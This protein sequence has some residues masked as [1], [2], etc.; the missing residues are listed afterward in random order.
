MLRTILLLLAVILLAVTSCK[1]SKQARTTSKK[2]KTV[3]KTPVKEKEQES[4]Q[5]AETTPEEEKSDT[6]P[7]FHDISID[8]ALS[9]IQNKFPDTKT[10][11][12]IFK[13]KRL[14]KKI[15]IG[16]VTAEEI[17]RIAET[18]KGTPHSFNGISKKGIDCSGLVAVSFRQSGISEFP[19]GSQEQAYYGKII[20]KI[21]QLQRG[22]LVFFTNTYQTPNLLTHVGIYLGNN[23]FIHSTTSKGVIVTDFTTSEYWRRHYAF[24]TRLF[25]PA[26]TVA[27]AG[28]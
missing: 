20:L 26:Q 25:N 5:P 11:G 27:N 1:P 10:K 18:Y 28:K 8:S 4:S 7:E 24:A 3:A 19:H 21:N 14:G 2:S 16:Q 9:F 12:E 13:N 6:P 15:N 22:D 23:K 17:I